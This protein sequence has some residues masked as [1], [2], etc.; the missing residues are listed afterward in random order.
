MSLYVCVCVCEVWMSK[1][2]I[3]TRKGETVI[4]WRKGRNRESDRENRETE[5]HRRMRKTEKKL[6]KCTNKKGRQMGFDFWEKSLHFFLQLW[7]ETFWAASC[8]KCFM[9]QN[10]NRRGKVFLHPVLLSS[11]ASFLSSLFFLLLLLSSFLPRNLTKV[12]QIEFLS[13]QSTKIEQL[14]RI[15]R[16]SPPW[17]WSVLSALFFSTLSLSLSLFLSNGLLSCYSCPPSFSPSFQWQ[18]DAWIFLKMPSEFES[19]TQHRKRVKMFYPFL[20][21]LNKLDSKLRRL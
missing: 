21:P 10:R 13:N 9:Y 14:V 6:Q 2:Y 19:T 11:I 18:K 4:H 17:D 15:G 12:K 1:K 5:K 3:Y 7:L 8:S 20:E 16:E